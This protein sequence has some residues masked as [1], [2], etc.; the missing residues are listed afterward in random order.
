VTFATPILAAIAAAIA[1]PT[2]VILY[3][4]KLRRRDMEVSSTLLWKKAIQDL[5][6]N[7]PFQKLRN[8]ILLIL[9]LLALAAALLALAQPE[10]R[11]RGVSTARRIIMI[12]RSASMN[13]TDGDAKPGEASQPPTPAAGDAPSPAAASTTDDPTKP[14]PSRLAAA[15]KKA[16]ELV[17]SLKEPGLFDDKAEEAMVIAF[18]TSAVVVQ[19]FTTNKDQLKSA[20]EG[21]SPSDAPSSLGQAYDLARAY[22]GS[23][24]FEDQVKE[25]VNGKPAGFVA[26][27]PTATLHI[28]S[29]GRLPDAEKIQTAPEDSVVYHAVGASD[30]PNLAITGL[31]AERSFDNPAR[32]IIFIGLQSTDTT[33]RSVD[34]ELT[35]DGQ[36]QSIKAIKVAAATQPI[37]TD[38]ARNTPDTSNNQP[39]KPKV[40]PAKPRVVPGLGG[41]VFPI[42][43]VT[44]GVATVRLLVTERDA[45]ATDNAAY[46]TI[47]PA[48]RLSVVL[49]TNGNLFIKSALDGLGL[50]KFDIKSPEQ[51][52]AMLDK[53]EDGGVAQYDVAIFDRVLPTVT[54]SDKSKGPGLPPG[55]SLVLGA[56][57]PPPL[58]LLDDGPGDL[59]A[60]A[61]Y[62][63]DHLALRLASLDKITI[64]K[65]RKVRIAPDT[66]VKKL[67]EF[68]KMGP[69]IVE[70]TDVTRQAIVIP[71]DVADS[72]WPFDPGW[73]LFLASSVLHLS[74]TQAGALSEGIRAG[75]TLT[76]RLPPGS[77]KVRLTPPE[78]AGDP[79]NL[80]QA[81]DGTV[82]FGPIVRDGMYTV[83]WEGQATPLDEPDGAT[84]RRR[85]A[86]NLLDPYE[87][88]IGSVD[89]LSLA[90]DEYQS[91]TERES[92]LTRRLWPYLLL[93]ALGVMMF[94][95]FIYNRKVA[96]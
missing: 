80:E 14:H 31:R 3:F 85:I 22:T 72:D 81:P 77:E 83:S 84:A 63:R 10:L 20:I 93:G 50:S 59:D 58:G 79:V 70:I 41:V 52:Q 15:K 19:T 73:V 78:G 34:A 54:L 64:S 39:D 42:E 62:E 89:R 28:F 33:P 56:V 30:A 7:A 2:L 66:P 57:P 82:S 95:W 4:L 12:D 48:K 60:I 68:T 17:T 35:I 18:D 21:I 45:L 76:T 96:L 23:K 38:T 92:D 13:A 71:W 94:E 55:R 43:R 25:E 5:Q 11:H 51:Y 74:D 75:D 65:T 8:N 16:L 46:L 36:P 53:G 86:V 44:G 90:R 26:S 24:K 88:D 6:A 91:Q 87:S 37:G 67:A 49:V 69:A 29:D 9:Q 40:A 47:P 27:G 1:I 32:V 61:S